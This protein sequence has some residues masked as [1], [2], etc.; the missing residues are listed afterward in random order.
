MS[1]V[2]SGF[3]A[4]NG[5]SNSDGATK[6]AGTLN[7]IA[8]IWIIISSFV[9]GYANQPTPLW[10][11]IVLG[12]IVVVVAWIRLGNFGSIPNIAWV[13][14]IAGIW[15]FF[16]PWI[17]RFSELSAAV[18]NNLILGIIVFILSVWG[19]AT[20]HQRHALG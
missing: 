14:L 3:S 11:G 16:S 13:N 4:G 2:T 20:S 9:L 8:G 18:G 6:T 12:V 10:N 17:L 5:T 7:I 1:R 15:L 19:L